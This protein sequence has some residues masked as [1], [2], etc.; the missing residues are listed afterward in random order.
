MPLIRSN[1][2][3]ARGVNQEQLIG[4]I[5]LWARNSATNQ[6]RIAV[7]AVFGTHRMELAACLHALFTRQREI[8]NPPMTNRPI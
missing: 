3:P 1:A 2:L 7:R 5:P 6:D 8:I 4:R